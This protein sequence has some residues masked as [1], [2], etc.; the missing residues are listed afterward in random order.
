MQ[1]RFVQV[2]YYHVISYHPVP[3]NQAIKLK[4]KNKINKTTSI[5]PIR[6]PMP[7]QCLRTSLVVLYFI[8]HSSISDPPIQTSQ[9][10]QLCHCQTQSQLTYQYTLIPEDFPNHNWRIH[11]STHPLIYMFLLIVNVNFQNSIQFKDQE[12]DLIGDIETQNPI[13]NP[14]KYF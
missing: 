10:P 6:T 9:Q 11:Q 14:S 1:I 12:L 3:T 4:I 2:D 13:T 5:N 8:L 7:S